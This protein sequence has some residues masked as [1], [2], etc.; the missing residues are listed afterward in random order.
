MRVFST[1]SHCKS[2]PFNSLCYLTA[3]SFLNI[4]LTFFNDR[5]KKSMRANLR[6]KCRLSY[7]EEIRGER[8]RCS[9][10]VRPERKPY[11][12]PK[13]FKFP[14]RTRLE[15]LPTIPAIVEPIKFRANNYPIRLYSGEYSC[16]LYLS[17]KF[18][19]TISHIF[20]VKSCVIR[21]Y[22]GQIMINSTVIL[23]NNSG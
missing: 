7:R 2:N 10:Y 8:S 12:A 21:L 22:R 6:P 3:V 9:A 19:S 5:R 11:V 16:V 1:N 18:T 13:P 14:N 20:T 15:T 17:I 23:M 4:S